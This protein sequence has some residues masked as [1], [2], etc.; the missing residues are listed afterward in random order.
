MAGCTDGYPVNR[1]TL[2]PTLVNIILHNIAYT[3]NLPY[4]DSC[5]AAYR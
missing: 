4:S 1:F 3:E 2:N 5:N